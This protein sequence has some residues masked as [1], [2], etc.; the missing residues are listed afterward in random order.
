M[1]HLVIMQELL[2]GKVGEGGG[3]IDT[4]VEFEKYALRWCAR[5]YEKAGKVGGSNRWNRSA[6]RR[7]FYFMVRLWEDRIDPETEKVIFNVLRE[8]RVNQS[9][10][11][12]SGGA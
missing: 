12:R 1:M 10:L 3:G 11:Y 2:E 7:I 5:I 9:V 8:S 4:L 6:C